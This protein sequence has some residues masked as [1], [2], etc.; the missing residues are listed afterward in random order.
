LET[1]AEAG[2]WWLLKQEIGGVCAS[3]AVVAN[4]NNLSVTV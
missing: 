2:N 3:H 4:S 1:P